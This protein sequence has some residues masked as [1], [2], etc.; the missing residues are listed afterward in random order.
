MRALPDKFVKKTTITQKLRE[1]ISNSTSF[2]KKEEISYLEIGCDICMTILSLEDSFTRILG[3]DIDPERI[4]E[5]KR[6]IEKFGVKE[7]KITLLLGSSDDIPKD[8]YDVV[9]IDANHNYEYVK[10]DYENVLRSNMSNKFVVFFH[11]YGLSNAGVKKFVKDTFKE[12]EI[13][14]CGVK[15]EWNPFGSPIDDWEAVYVIHD[16]KI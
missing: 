10:R 15:D 9:L 8:Y 6:Q 7:G 16:S 1:E 14:F 5:S 3:V 12:N 13:K 11:D 4:N 2:F